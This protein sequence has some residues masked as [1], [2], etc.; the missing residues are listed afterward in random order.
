M[1]LAYCCPNIKISSHPGAQHKW[2]CSTL[3]PKV[4]KPLIREHSKLRYAT[5][6][7][8][9]G[10][11]CRQNS[12]FCKID[13][14]GSLLGQIWV[15]PIVNGIRQTNQIQIYKLVNFCW[16]EPG[17]IVEVKFVSWIEKHGQEV[18]QWERF[19]KHFEN[20]KF[21]KFLAV[22][23]NASL[24]NIELSFNLCHQWTLFLG[25]GF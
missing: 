24:Q 3:P 16:L 5:R 2:L 18:E 8:P 4:M 11:S 21:Q 14:G 17:C 1:T 13:G 19:I 23:K 6:E 10:I 25:V 7:Y 12:H 15:T 9:L 22:S 20:A